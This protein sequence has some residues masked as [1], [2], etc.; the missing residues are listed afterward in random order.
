MSIA[1]PHLIKLYVVRS[2][3]KQ[4]RLS[5]FIETG[6][7]L[8][9]TTEWMAREGFDV[10]T[11]ELSGELYSLAKE[12]LKRYANVQLILGD[13]AQL[14]P[15]LLSR[16]NEPA[17]F[18]LDAHY[19][20]GETAKGKIDTPIM[21]ELKAIINHPIRSHVILIDDVRCLSNLIHLKEAYFLS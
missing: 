3:S 5:E 12:R 18:W 16:L 15:E 13:S 4:F 8:G 10:I 2:Y 17:C 14:L 7:H 6:T 21:E 9:E 1:P 11:I 20:G 19:S